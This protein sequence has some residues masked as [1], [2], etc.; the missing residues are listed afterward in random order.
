[1]RK[2]IERLKENFYSCLPIILL[3][4]IPVLLLIIFC[5]AW[6]ASNQ[7]TVAAVLDKLSQIGYGSKILGGILTLFAFFAGV[8]LLTGVILLIDKIAKKIPNFWIYIY[9]I[10]VSVGVFALSRIFA[11]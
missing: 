1:M 11:I 4:G 2:F 5:G 8:N 6:I 10:S 9:C 7:D 3:A